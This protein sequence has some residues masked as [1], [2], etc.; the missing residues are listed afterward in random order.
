MEPSIEHWSPQ[1][2]TR[3]TNEQRVIRND[4]YKITGDLLFNISLNFGCIT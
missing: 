2:E 3:A 1:G 4:A